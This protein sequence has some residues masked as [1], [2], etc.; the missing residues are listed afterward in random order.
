MAR[1]NIE[2][3]TVPLSIQIQRVQAKNI[4][5]SLSFAGQIALYTT[6]MT[7]AN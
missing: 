3:L 4:G 7:T 2:S 5:T 6:L 1:V